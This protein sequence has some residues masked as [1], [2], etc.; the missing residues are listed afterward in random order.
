MQLECR[1]FGP[2]R[3]DVGEQTVSWNPDGDTVGDLLRELEATYP[4]LEGRLVDDAGTNLAGKTV[5]TKNKTD[6][7]HLGGLET[8]L[9]DGDVF[10]LVPSVYGGA[11]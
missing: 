7:R 4:I 10:R 6:V 8:E 9:E 2:F 5:V 3:D 1:F 11:V